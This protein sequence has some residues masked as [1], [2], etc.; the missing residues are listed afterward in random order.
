MQV[1]F[2]IKRTFTLLHLTFT[3]YHF[4]FLNPANPK[5]FCIFAFKALA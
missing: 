5:T 2:D 1:I 4:S 3:I